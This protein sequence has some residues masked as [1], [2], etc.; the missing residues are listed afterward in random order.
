MAV[1]SESAEK[2][3]PMEERNAAAMFC[4]LCFVLFYWIANIALLLIYIFFKAV[5]F[6]V[7]NNY[8]VLVLISFSNN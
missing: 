8:L 4:D 5:I 1:P 7:T 2:H 6:V 3:T